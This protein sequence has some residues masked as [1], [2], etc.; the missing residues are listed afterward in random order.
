MKLSEKH[1]KNLLFIM[2]FPYTQM[3]DFQLESLI[4]YLYFVPF[5]LI[6]LLILCFLIYWHS[7][8]MNGCWK[9]SFILFRTKFQSKINKWKFEGMSSVHK[10]KKITISFRSAHFQKPTKFNK[11][12]YISFLKRKN[13]ILSFPTIPQNSY[14]SCLILSTPNSLNLKWKNLFSKIKRKKFL[15]QI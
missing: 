3:M 15:S 14:F 8:K 5:T 10:I 1:L 11:K 6:A 4:L 12:T 13:P 9:S 2:Y 7:K